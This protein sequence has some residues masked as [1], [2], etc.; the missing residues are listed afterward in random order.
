MPL[1]GAHPRHEVR[2][3]PD[4]QVV[5]VRE[6]VNTPPDDAGEFGPVDLVRAGVSFLVTAGRQTLGKAVRNVARD[7]RM[8][9]AVAARLR[10]GSWGSRDAR[11]VRDDTA[12]V[13]D[14]FA[15]VLD[16]GGETDNA[17]AGGVGR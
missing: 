7:R 12:N 8:I 16:P 15:D 6:E 9:D 3:E 5:G 17:G 10:G 2:E 11:A 13:L 1:D 14:A 4:Q